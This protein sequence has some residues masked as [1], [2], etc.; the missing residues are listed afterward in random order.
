MKNI[1]IIAIIVI[2]ILSGYFLYHKSHEVKK[3]MTQA[4]CLP[5]YII[6]DTDTCVKA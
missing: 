2:A 4:P 5:G 1:Q 6:S 3:I